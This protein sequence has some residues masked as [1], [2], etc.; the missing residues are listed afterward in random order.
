MR[1][2]PAVLAMAIC[3]ASTLMAQQR[4]IDTA[5]STMT[6]RVYRSGLFS[7]FAHNHEI[8]APIASGATDEQHMVELTVKSADLK[9]LDPDL[10]AKDRAQ[11]QQTMLGPQ[12]LD[13]AVFPQIHF[14]STQLE[15]MGTG[16]WRVRGD[17]TLHGV[18]RPVDVEVARENGRYRGAATLKQRDFGMKPI[19]I[20]GGTVSVKNEVRV[21]FD[22]ALR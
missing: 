10:S 8:R 21:E 15:P 16:K 3:V 11:V 9:V 14:R 6:V 17:L 20:A 12:V 19:K 5:R 22:I 1:L 4:T 13:V 7:V 2:A 18:T